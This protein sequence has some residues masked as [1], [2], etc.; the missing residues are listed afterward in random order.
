MFNGIDTEIDPEFIE[1]KEVIDWKL[2]NYDIC[3]LLDTIEHLV[4]PIFCL[5]KINNS[6][7]EWLF[8]DYYR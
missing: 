8:A 3:Y 4:D 5:D 7:K 2:N 6:L 1:P